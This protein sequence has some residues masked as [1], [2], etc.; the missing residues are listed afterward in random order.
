MNSRNALAVHR[1]LVIV[2][3]FYHV[4]TLEIAI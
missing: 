4:N 3:A 2:F 1:Q